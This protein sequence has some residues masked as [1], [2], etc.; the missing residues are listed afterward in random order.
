MIAN[1]SLMKT[2][3][4]QK[5]IFPLLPPFSPN[6]P[7]RGQFT[8]SLPNPEPMQVEWWGKFHMNGFHLTNWSKKEKLPKNAYFPLFPKI[9]PFGGKSL[10]SKLCLIVEWDQKRKCRIWPQ[11]SIAKRKNAKSC[12]FAPFPHYFPNFPVYREIMGKWGKYATF[13]IF[14][15]CNRLLRPNSTFSL[16]I[17]SL[18][19]A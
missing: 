12:I 4:G 10:S 16:L 7:P 11:K 5:S 9:S 19:E 18:Y 2:S 14:S 3:V 1:W 13:C 6:F 15:F 8:K 17:P